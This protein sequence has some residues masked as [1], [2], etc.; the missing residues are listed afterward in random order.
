[1]KNFFLLKKEKEKESSPF[2]MVLWL[3]A[4]SAWASS[5]VTL[6]E[7]YVMCFPYLLNEDGYH[8]DFIGLLQELN[9]LL[10]GKSL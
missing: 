1:M 3:W 6:G 5:C 10:Q 4:T 8:P 7:F 9:E 2:I